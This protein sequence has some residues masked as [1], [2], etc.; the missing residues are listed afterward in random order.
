LWTRILDKIKVRA[1][2]QADETRMRMQRDANGK[3]KNGFV[4]TFVAVDDDD[5]ERDVALVLAANRSGHTPKAHLEGT[6]GYLL[7]EAYS[8]YNAVLEVSSRV[9]VG[10]HA[11][12][13]RYLHDALPTAPGA[14]EG[15]DII[16]ELYAVEREA[17][18]RGIFGKASHL[19]FRKE[20][21]GPV[22]TRLKEWLEL[23]RPKHR[24]KSPMATA[25]RYGLN[26]WEALGHFLDDVRVPLDNNA[27]EAALRR[28]ALGRKN[29]LFVNDVDAGTNIAGLYTLIATCESRGVN[30]FAYLADVLLRVEDQPVDRIDELLPGAWAARG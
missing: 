28:V 21:A 6:A 24:P 12:L 16:G 26:Q 30:P 3:A 15:L 7:T 18:A 1:V 25:I 14:Q 20:R 9:R 5:G 8:A 10:C 22:R 27:S 13:R 29:F 19:D 23:E 4:W 2:V 11:H 17:R